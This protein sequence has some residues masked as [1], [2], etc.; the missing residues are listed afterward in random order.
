MY[1]SNMW[2]V[3]RDA[4]K[5]FACAIPVGVFVY[6]GIVV[7]HYIASNIYPSICTPLTIIGFIMTPLMIVSPY[8]EALRWV[9]YYTG[10]LIRNMWLWLAGYLILCIGNVLSPYLLSPQ[11]NV[12]F[13]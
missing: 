3:V 10:T 11:K 12:P 9:V 5:T 6:V 2:S 7:I 8:C 1:C 4:L 13:V